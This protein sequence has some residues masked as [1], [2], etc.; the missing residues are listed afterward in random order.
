MK[1]PQSQSAVQSVT[2]T[3]CNKE[4]S[5]TAFG[6]KKS[7]KEESTYPPAPGTIT[8]RITVPHSNTSRMIL[9]L[10]TKSSRLNLYTYVYTHISIHVHI[11]KSDLYSIP[12]LTFVTS[13]GY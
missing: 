8:A 11:N 7:K 1:K 9:I 3:Y 12:V 4:G 2:I 13:L 5:Y 6:K 10:C